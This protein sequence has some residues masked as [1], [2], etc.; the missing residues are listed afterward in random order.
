MDQIL[1]VIF[2]D[3]DYSKAKLKL[4][5]YDSVQFIGCSFNEVHL[6]RYQFLDCEFIS[7][8]LDNA[9]L[10]ETSIKNVH[11]SNCRMQGLDFRGIDPM[12]FEM[13]V[14]D[15]NLSFANFSGLDLKKCSF[16]NVIFKSVDFY[17]SDLEKIT[18]P[19][20]DFKDA[21]FE[22]TILKECDFSEASNFIINPSY[23]KI[24]GATFSRHSID[25]ILRGMGIKLVD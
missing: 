25:G 24:K 19:G 8:T 1:D 3:K 14:K 20:C 11:F 9:F 21:L 22:S 23:N 15:C 10:N 16:E 6:E 4:A 17:E 12:F 7:C 18:F 2:K 13:H 5:L